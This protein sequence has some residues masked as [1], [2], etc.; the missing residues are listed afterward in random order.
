VQHTTTNPEGKQRK[1]NEEM[2][3][4]ATRYD[5]TILT[6]VCIQMDLMEMCCEDGE[7]MELAQ[8]RVQ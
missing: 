4:H 5:F 1:T 8:D 2:L 3:L 7:W 6:E